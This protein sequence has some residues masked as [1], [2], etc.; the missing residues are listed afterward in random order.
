[1]RLLLPTGTWALLMA[2][3]LAG[4]ASAQQACGALNNGFGP[5][6]YRPSHYVAGPGDSQPHAEKLNLVQIAHF[7]PAVESLIR[8]E[9][10]RRPGG[11]IDYTLRAFPNHHRAL[12][13]V[14]RLG[15][16]EKREQPIGMRYPVDCW[17]E[18]AVRFR[19]DDVIVRMI[20]ASY[21]GKKGRRD[22]A[23]L[24]LGVVDRLAADNPFTRY[25][26]G[27]TYFELGAFEE[28]LAQAHRAMALGMQ[29]AELKEQLVAAGRWREP[30]P[31][32]AAD[33]AASAA[34]AAR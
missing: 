15:E 34:S 25:N 28:A 11:D 7:T 2:A 4:K 1:M 16:V 33:P 21:F 24:D 3:A 5:F 14:I 32:A 29:R 8:G 27:L 19:P 30:E 18:R 31:T 23:M 20:R 9:T 13:A 6:D 12:L 26:L 22:D 17:L 10:S